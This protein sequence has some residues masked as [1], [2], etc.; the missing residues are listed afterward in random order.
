MEW[1]WGKA[2]ARR[3][4]RHIWSK[5]W[6]V[7]HGRSKAWHHRRSRWP[8]RIHWTWRKHRGARKHR[9]VKVEVWSIEKGWRHHW[10]VHKWM[11]GLVHERM[12]RP[13]WGSVWHWTVSNQM[14]HSST[15]ETRSLNQTLGCLWYHRRSIRIKGFNGSC[16]RGGTRLLRYWK[17]D[18]C[19][20][21]RLD[22]FLFGRCRAGRGKWWQRSNGWKL[23][24]ESRAFSAAIRLLTSCCSIRHPLFHSS[25]FCYRSYVTQM[26]FHCI[27]KGFVWEKVIWR[28]GLIAKWA[29][30]SLNQGR[31]NT[32]VAGALPTATNEHCILEQLVA[33]RTLE[34]IRHCFPVC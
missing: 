34:Q 20:G 7:S 17:G 12:G 1:A 24:L 5:G 22:R 33:D 19:R 9:I 16:S 10:I 25:L 3:V 4:R 26:V 21:W 2:E 31:A 32:L 15:L 6:W 18:R 27:T 14:P 29:S 28:L 30:E 13:H 11:W 23:G 8:H